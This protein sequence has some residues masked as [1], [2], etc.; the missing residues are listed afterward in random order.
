MKKAILA[1]LALPLLLCSCDTTSGQQQPGQNTNGEGSSQTTTGEGI[2]TGG[3]TGG[4]TT[5]HED[6]PNGYNLDEWHNWSFSDGTHP[7]YDDDWDFYYGDS[8]K[9]AGQ[10]WEN[11]NYKEYSGME[12]V[13]NCYAIS[14]QFDSYLKVEMRFYF[15]F[16]SHQSSK[17]N[18]TDNQPQFLI[19]EY[20]SNNKLLGTDKIEI[21]KSDIPKNNTPKECKVY[22]FQ[23][24]MTWFKL[25]FNNYIEN[26][27]GGYSAILTSVG[28][29]GWEY[30]SKL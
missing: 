30:E 24:K 26:S 21:A 16:S 8:H 23:N 29:K 12:F 13:K 1:L 11:T 4:G 17:Y 25:K 5:T 15:W 20:D 14:P 6:N 18:A 19:E 3:E 10:L 7:C 22:V 28:L 27:Q 2:Q 9:P